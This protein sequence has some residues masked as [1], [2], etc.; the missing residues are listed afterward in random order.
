[1]SAGK[2]ARL[3]ALKALLRVDQEKGYSNLVLD[4][5]L[6]ASG[7][8]GR[9]AA[10]AS[11]LV[12]GVLERRI[13][14]DYQISHYSKMPLCQMA[15][16]VREILRLGFYQLLYMDKVPQSAAVN[17]SVKLTRAV[18]KDRASGFVNGILRSFIRDGCPCRL[19][20]ETA[21]DYLTVKYA[22]PQWI[23]DLWII[24]YGR[25]KALELLEH[26]AGRPPLAVRVNSYK[27]TR[28][29]LKERLKEEGVAASEVPGVELALILEGSGSL[30][31]LPSF[32]SGLFHVQ[33][34]ASQL[35][36]QTLSPKP[37]ER[38]YDVCAAPGGKTFT[39][40]ELMENQGE[41]L[42]FD[43]YP[44]K[45]GLIREGAERLGLSVVNAQIRDAAHP[46][47]DLPPG[48]KVLC[49]V[50][51]SGLGIIR[52]K[53]EIRY[54]N[55]NMLD[56]LPN[57][58]YLILCISANLTKKDGVL[59]YSTCTLN[60]EENNQIARR[61]LR[62]HP[63]FEPYPVSL[64]E[65]YER[66]GFDQENEATLLVGKNGTDGFFFSGFRR[67]R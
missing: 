28:E 34:L 55:K 12:Y 63:D 44:A 49:D 27:I 40:A 65:G 67:L 2:N 3:T 57:L 56:S 47:K 8:D 24:S 14:L 51:C 36:C 26:L 53:P 20:K 11:A 64:P 54:K 60:P 39:M 19:P 25:E 7:L 43:L 16:P 1:M 29:D 22:C 13:T 62:E 66:N 41:L 59:V 37:G 32:Q 42:S 45:V 31:R 18:K 48:D 35:C 5:G 58:Q 61:F 23:I 10:F 38:V 46:E 30:E 21:E 52:R 50:P 17:E 4:H 6:T 33:D 15:A 9:D